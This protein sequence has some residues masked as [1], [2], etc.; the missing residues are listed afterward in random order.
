MAHDS[1]FDR[2]WVEDRLE[3]ARQLAW[4]CSM[5]QVDWKARGFDGRVLGYLLV[6]AGFYHCG[7][8]ASAD[9]DTLIQLLRHSDGA[10]RTALAEMIEC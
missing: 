10:G 1:R 7:H 6:Q 8:R 4:T 2:A 3:D 9:V 5:A